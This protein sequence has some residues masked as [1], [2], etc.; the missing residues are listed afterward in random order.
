[1][2]YRSFICMLMIFT[3]SSCS[4]LHVR[5]PIIEQGNIITNEDV[6]KLHMGMSRDQVTAIMGQPVLNNIFSSHR[7]AY[8][9]TYEDGSNPRIIKRLICVFNNGRLVE[10]RRS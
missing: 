9:Y 7:M 1:M 10:M 3:L 8:I 5:R 4:Y 6:S 2:L